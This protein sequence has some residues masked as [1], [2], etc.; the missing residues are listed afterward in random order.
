MSAPGRSSGSRK[1]LEEL[2]PELG[3]VASD[4]LGVSGRLLLEALVGGRT[5]PGVLAD[6]ARGALRKKLAV[7]RE[8]L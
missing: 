5:D 7:L 6:L 4:V 3:C 8:A 2:G 1:L